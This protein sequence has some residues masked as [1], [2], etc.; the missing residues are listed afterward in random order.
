MEDYDV[1]EIPGRV[2]KEI[3]IRSVINREHYVNKDISI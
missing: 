3:V 2:S 1:I